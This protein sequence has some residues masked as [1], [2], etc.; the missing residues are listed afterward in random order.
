[1]VGATAA[2]VQT[3]LELLPGIDPGDVSV[4]KVGTVDNIQ[5]LLTI[6]GG[7]GNVAA[8]TGQD[9]AT[10]GKGSE[11]QLLKVQAT[12]GTFTLGLTA[13]GH[14]ATSSALAYNA[15]AAD[16]ASAVESLA[17]QVYT[18][19]TINSGDIT[20]QAAGPSFV[21]TFGG[22]LTGIDIAPL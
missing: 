8:S 9:G 7:A 10:P 21:I 14:S 16:I 17:Q 11:I 12:G 19:T 22:A 18:D 4:R 15:D 5:G 6:D 2:M 1:P 20:V 13:A 3:A